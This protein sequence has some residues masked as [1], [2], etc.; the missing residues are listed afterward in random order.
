MS[1]K[2]TKAI[3]LFVNKDSISMLTHNLISLIK[4]P[5]IMLL[6][7]MFLTEVEQG[8]WYTIGSLSALSTFADLGFGTLVGQFSAHEFSKL[9]FDKN[10]RYTGENSDVERIASLYKY[11]LKWALC[12][13]VV[14]YPIIMGV[15]IAVLNSHGNM[16][17]WITPWIIYMLAGGLSFIVRISLSF[18]EGCNQISK[19]QTNYCISTIAL[20]GVTIGMLVGKCGLYALAIPAVIS[21][22]INFS[23]M[24]LVFRHAIIQLLKTKVVHN[25]HWGRNFLSLIWKYA[26]SWASGY[27]IFQIYTPLAFMFYDPVMAGK[28]GITMTLIQA[29]FN[30]AN[31]FNAMFIPR[32]NIFV[33]NREWAKAEGLIKKGL[34]LS[35]PLYVL[36]ATIIMLALGLG[37]GR[38]ALFDRFLPAS[39]VIV[40]IVAWLI[41]MPINTIATYGRA[42][43]QEP[44]LIMSVVNSLF[45]LGSTVL[46]MYLL[47]VNYI[48]AGFALSNFVSVFIFVAMY[49]K[50]KN[51]WH[52]KLIL[53]QEQDKLDL[54]NE[55]KGETKGETNEGDGA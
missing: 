47:P 37:Q 39:I 19:I 52:Q 48:F 36:G 3:K 49:I 9:R 45:T 17:A 12:V 1:N 31:T 2:L 46:F 10:L 21:F 13:C 18:F 44:F 53:R 26:I 5:I 23:L 30:I 43:K 34:L 15:G 6:V 7:P 41:Q 8:Y 27:F 22:L 51:K 54:E 32:I 28:V 25:H 20:A 42:H 14:A 33:A 55:L 35:M 29:C 40:L 11:V 16:G 38:I 24:L 4:G 50:Q